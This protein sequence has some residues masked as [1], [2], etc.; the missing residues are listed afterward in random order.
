[1]FANT[2]DLAGADPAREHD[3][4]QDKAALYEVVDSL[5]AGGATPLYD[6]AYKAVQWAAAQ[7]AG[8]R[9]VLL[10]TDGKEEKAAGGGSQ[11]ANED[12]AVREANRAGVPIFTIGLGA[13][14]DEAYLKRVALETGGTYQHAAQSSELVQLFRNVSDLLKQQ[15]RV[16]YTSSVPADG[17][18]HTVQVMVKVDQHSA[19]QEAAVGPLPL[20][21]TPA[22]T[23]TP[24]SSTETPAPTPTPVAPQPTADAG[25][26]V[27]PAPT[28]P[29]PTASTFFTT[30]L[31]GLP[32]WLWAGI[33]S[34]A[35]AIVALLLIRGRS[36]RP[37]EPV[38]RCLRC[39]HKLD[40][41]DAPCPSC[42]FGGTYT[43]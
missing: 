31:L 32:T 25:K 12:S 26:V 1:A 15:Y 17:Q 19:S 42:G 27:A 28:A 5:Q 6:T 9:A 36:G 30:T 40:G 23:P 35:L 24:A 4:S 21:V 39:G 2:I 41:P 38:Y 8:N 34:L 43:G 18:T 11:V 20:L 7:P 16:T 13:D 33:A 10:F 22:P 29:A 14:A 3:F 37:S